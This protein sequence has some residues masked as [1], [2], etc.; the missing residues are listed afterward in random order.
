MALPDDADEYR[1]DVWSEI[2]EI[3]D[4]ITTLIPFAANSLE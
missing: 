2:L 4:R 3:Q 1:R